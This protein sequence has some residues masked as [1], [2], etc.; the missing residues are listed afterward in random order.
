MADAF[1][2][3]KI[4]AHD[5]EASLPEP[6]A[7]RHDPVRQ[8]GLHT[9]LNGKTREDTFG[10]REHF[11]LAWTGLTLTEYASLVSLVRG[12][13]PLSFVC[14]LGQY[15]VNL[16]NFEPGDHSLG[17]YVSCAMELDEAV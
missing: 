7:F 11:Y 12:T 9:I 15:S 2:T 5:A 10:I 6:T 4:G 1:G 3:F 17:G 13:W 8:S 16:A 14:H